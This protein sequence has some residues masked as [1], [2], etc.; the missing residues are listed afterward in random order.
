MQQ[1]RLVA[2]RQLGTG[3]QAGGA[4]MLSVLAYRQELGNPARSLEH[5]QEHLTK[6]GGEDENVSAVV[7]PTM[8]RHSRTRR[9]CR[10]RVTHA[11]LR[12]ASS[13][14]PVSKMAATT[15]F[16]PLSALPNAVL[17]RKDAARTSVATRAGAVRF[18]P[19]TTAGVAGMGVQRV[20]LSLRAAPRGRRS[21]GVVRVSANADDAMFVDL[22]PG[23]S[24]FKVGVQAACTAAGGC[25]ESSGV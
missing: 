9:A 12:S 17:L 16:A 3:Q 13:K 24:F 15:R 6:S 19:A 4:H 22:C 1:S 23:F 20:A 5:G 18:T 2:V 7:R 21:R 11:E 10:L 25:A 14:L 8:G